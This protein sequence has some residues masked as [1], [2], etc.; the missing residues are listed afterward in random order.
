VSTAEVPTGKA[1]SPESLAVACVAVVLSAGAVPMSCAREPEVPACAV[2]DAALTGTPAP[3]VAEVRWTSDVAGHG[4]VIWGYT[5][6]SLSYE[7]K[8]GGSGTTEHAV[9]V[10]GPAPATPVFWR[11]VTRTA[12][13]VCASP[14]SAWT[15]GEADWVDPT[16]EF[17][18]SSPGFHPGFRV[19][20][21]AIGDARVVV[22]DDLGRVAWNWMAPL[23]Y[24]IGEAHVDPD[25]L[26]FRALGVAEDLESGGGALFRVRF[27]RG[28]E[29]AIALPHCHHGFEVLGD[30]RIV[31]IAADP[32]Q[33]T[34]E[35]GSDTAT[36]AG[37]VLVRIGPSGE[38][39]EILFSGWDHWLPD[40]AVLRADDQHY[41]ETWL[42][43]T[44]AN[45]VHA[46]PGG[47]FL[48]SFRKTNTVVALDDDGA[49]LWTLTGADAP[50]PG[51]LVNL[52]DE[53]D[54]FYAQHNAV[55]V[56]GGILLF[57]N[58]PDDGVSWSEVSEFEVDEDALTFRRRW[59]HDWG[60]RLFV[61]R[62]GDVQRFDDGGTLVNWGSGGHMTEVDAAGR[63]VWELEAPRRFMGYSEHHAGLGGV[64]AAGEAR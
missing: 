33:V 59:T 56:D 14:V 38:D 39:E 53:A 5:P 25:G 4:A 41:Y 15:P 20:P 18:G 51:D 35:D 58:G 17:H 54:L 40:L 45:S 27:D 9:Q 26:G 11:A 30:G 37:D 8:P 43:W 31:Y 10:V 48:M 49:L 6:E 36:V 57:D 19:V 50:Y 44:H 24:G 29:E 34:S 22:L 47:G 23:G 64:L 13:G 55:D 2:S 28:A 42:D 46:R 7:T 62:Q 60:R 3:T 52:G 12:D 61:K 21:M 32:R 1:G 16:V 63:V